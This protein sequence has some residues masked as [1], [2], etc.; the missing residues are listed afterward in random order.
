MLKTRVIFT[1]VW[2][3]PLTQL[4]SCVV[5]H[6]HRYISMTSQFMLKVNEV[7]GTFSLVS[8]VTRV[9]G[10]CELSFVARVCWEPGIIK[11]CYILV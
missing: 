1:V 2:A 6:D 4:L 5:S 11:A 10:I 3:V 8:V 7:R 9:C